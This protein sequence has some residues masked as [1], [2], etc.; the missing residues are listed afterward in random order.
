MHFV[1][2][3]FVCIV[4]RLTYANCFK[5]SKNLNNFLQEAGINVDGSIAV[6][7]NNSTTRTNSDLNIKAQF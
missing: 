1:V 4:R 6:T 3:C 2:F 5:C 7:A